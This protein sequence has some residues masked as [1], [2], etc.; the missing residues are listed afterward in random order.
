MGFTRLSPAV[1]ASPAREPVLG[2]RG[3]ALGL[4]GGA[5]VAGA[6]AA[7]RGRARDREPELREPPALSG[8]ASGPLS[9]LRAPVENDRREQRRLRS[10]RGGFWHGL[11]PP[12]AALAPRKITRHAHEGASLKE[13]GKQLKNT[14]QAGSPAGMK[15]SAPPPLRMRGRESPSSHLSSRG[16]GLLPRA[17]QWYSSRWIGSVSA[18]M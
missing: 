10:S 4:R 14:V 1:H 17:S 5:G 12:G 9:R 2:K 6:T 11:G 18:P 7:P 8:E 3:S 13:G 15:V 16:R